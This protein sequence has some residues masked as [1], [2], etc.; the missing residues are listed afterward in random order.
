MIETC[1]NLLHAQTSPWSLAKGDQPFIKVWV[2]NPSFW[3]E[4]VRT[5]EYLRVVVDECRTARDDCLNVD[6]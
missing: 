4:L 2:P 5:R 1:A 3:L 6:R